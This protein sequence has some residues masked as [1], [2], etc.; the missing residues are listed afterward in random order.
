EKALTRVIDCAMAVHREL[1]PGFLESIYKQAMC[2]EMASVGVGYDCEAPLEV[3]HRG[4]AIRGQRVDLIVEG[5]VVVELKAVS[6]LE[7]IHEAQ[8]ISYLKTTG[9]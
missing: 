5:L 9:L 3:N 8:L 7:D 6:R 2:I 4:V 1:G